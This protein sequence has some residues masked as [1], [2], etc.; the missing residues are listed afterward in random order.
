MARLCMLQGA[1]PCLYSVDRICSAV[2]YVVLINEGIPT[3]LLHGS[4]LSKKCRVS[5]LSERNHTSEGLRCM[6]E[7]CTLRYQA[8]QAAHLGCFIAARI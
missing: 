5:L 8:A 2:Q 6:S 4:S 1:Y 3:G 7:P